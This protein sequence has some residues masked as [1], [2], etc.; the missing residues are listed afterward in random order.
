MF[1]RYLIRAA[2]SLGVLGSTLVAVDAAAGDR[3][4]HHGA[5]CQATNGVDSDYNRSPYRITRLTG[6]SGHLVCPVA[7]DVFECSGWGGCVKGM[8]VEVSVLDWH[9]QSDI[10][11]TLSAHNATGSAYWWDSDKT[12]GMTVDTLKMSGS[13]HWSKFDSYVL[14]CTLPTNGNAGYTKLY[15]YTVNENN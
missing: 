2:L 6:S 7:H 1:D 12:A 9:S 11:C 4:M 8:S 5:F 14:E 10:S 13:A 3:H 15:S